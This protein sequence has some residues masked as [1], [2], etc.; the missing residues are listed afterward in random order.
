M[1]QR[2]YHQ[3]EVFTA[4]FE[5]GL[6][7]QIELAPEPRVPTAALPMDAAA[8]QLGTTR[9][10]LERWIRE[11]APVVRRGARGRGR[12]TLVNPAAIRSSTGTAR[13]DVRGVVGPSEKYQMRVHRPSSSRLF[14]VQS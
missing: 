3:W 11:G 13:G 4:G 12:R 10:T 14:S 9:R 5:A 6:G 8:E 7:Y 2:S 1:G